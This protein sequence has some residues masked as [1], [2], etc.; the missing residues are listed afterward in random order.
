MDD[1][2]DDDDDNHV[3][4]HE[5]AVG[6]EVDNDADLA[7]Y[8]LDHD[9]VLCSALD[10][11]ATFD[12]V[13]RIAERRPSSVRWMD[14]GNGAISLHAASGRRDASIVKFLCLE[15]PESVKTA[16]KRGRLALHHAS[17]GG[18]RAGLETFQ[19]LVDRHPESIQAKDGKGRIPLHYA[20]QSK[21]TV[22]VIEFLVGK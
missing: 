17:A 20:L 4:P 21:K 18:S 7:A 6:G 1:A 3:V 8:D 22:D 13:R 5:N 10:M 9:D 14:P 2:A 15:W 12:E 19:F 16:D 11:A